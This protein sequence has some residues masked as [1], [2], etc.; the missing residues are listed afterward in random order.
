MNEKGTAMPHGFK[1]SIILHILILGFFALP[2]LRPAKREIVPS[3]P[4]PIIFEKIEKDAVP[5]NKASK[6]PVPKLNKKRPSSKPKA[7]K[8]EKK[9]DK[10]PEIKIPEKLTPVEKMKKKDFSSLID[11]LDIPEKQEPD[12]IVEDVLKDLTPDD[13][14]PDG[15]QAERD[16]PQSIMDKLS[17]NFSVT[18]EDALRAQISDNWLVPVGA[19]D[20]ESM[21]VDIKIQV[22]KGG[23]VVS[24]K[25]VKNKYYQRGNRQYEIFVQSAKR[26]ILKS[27]PLE[28]SKERM[29]VENEIVFHFSPSDMF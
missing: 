12:L 2:I 14:K 22:E 18:E 21:E 27:S 28:L 4:I 20:I 29:Q 19:K 26:A 1:R 17:D 16:V 15:E 3:H 9:V 13:Y 7:P 25:E 5:H 6:K 23:K 11:D 8:V 10:K 24:V